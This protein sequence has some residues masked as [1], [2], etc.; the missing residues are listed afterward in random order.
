MTHRHLMVPAFGITQWYNPETRQCKNHE[1]R[2]RVC[3]EFETGSKQCYEWR[4]FYQA[5]LKLNVS[6]HQASRT[7]PGL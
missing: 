2:P 4:E 1:Y 7:R 5:K 3:R 6:E